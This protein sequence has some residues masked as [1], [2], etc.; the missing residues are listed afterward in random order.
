M[1]LETKYT[2]KNTRYKILEILL[3]TDIFEKYRFFYTNINYMNNI[4][5]KK[6]VSE[7]KKKNPYPSEMP[8][9][10]QCYQGYFPD[11]NQ[12]L[13]QKYLY[14]NDKLIIVFG[15]YLG[16]AVKFICENISPGMVVIAVDTWGNTV[17]IIIHERNFITHLLLILGNIAIKS[18]H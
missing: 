5:Y 4:V 2:C 10:D 15:A 6:I 11:S 18:Y 13:I 14:S 16:E 12:R 7:L 17:Q 8:K 9:L 1:E 3:K